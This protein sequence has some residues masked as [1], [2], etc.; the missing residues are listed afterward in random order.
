[1]EAQ[2]EREVKDELEPIRDGLLR[3]GV[4]KP[5]VLQA[6]WDGGQQFSA[7]ESTGPPTLVNIPSNQLNM[8]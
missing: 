1:M 3:F 2:E 7:P 8:E 6:L 5:H 4:Y